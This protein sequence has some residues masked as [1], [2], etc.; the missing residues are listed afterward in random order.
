MR[1]TCTAKT[2]PIFPSRSDL[3]RFGFVAGFIFIAVSANAHPVAQG[4]MGVEISPGKIHIQA[5]VSM[6]E[7]FVQNALSSGSNDRNVGPDDLCRR[8]GDYLLQHL[9]VFADGTA[10]PGSLTSF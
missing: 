1:F 4:S 5:R 10:L 7:V 9:F 8:H 3:L 2:Q 6:E